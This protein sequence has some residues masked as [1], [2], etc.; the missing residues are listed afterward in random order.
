M[1]KEALNWEAKEVPKDL[2]SMLLPTNLIGDQAAEG[3]CG[4]SWN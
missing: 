2:K 4:S 1:Y 3:S